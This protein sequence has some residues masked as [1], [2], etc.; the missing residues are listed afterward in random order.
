MGIHKRNREFSYLQYG[1]DRNYGKR[2]QLGV[3]HKIG[4]SVADCVL[5]THHKLATP[6]KKREARTRS[7]AGVP[8]QGFVVFWTNIRKRLKQKFQ[9]VLFSQN[10]S[11]FFI[12]I[13]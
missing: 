12:E 6:K 5:D 2:S 4:S 10:N 9:N 3:G 11:W 8:G 13:S 1:R 7:Q